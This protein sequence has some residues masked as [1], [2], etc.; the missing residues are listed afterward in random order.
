MTLRNDLEEV[1]QKIDNI[2]HEEEL[3][4]NVRGLTTKSRSHLRKAL[5]LTIRSET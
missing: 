3:P 1:I 2:L 4:I 5:K